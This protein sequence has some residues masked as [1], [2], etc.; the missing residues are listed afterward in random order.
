VDTERDE[1]D[2]SV[3][4]PHPHAGGWAAATT[5]LLGFLALILAQVMDTL[6]A[7]LALLRGLANVGYA[8]SSEIHTNHLALQIVAWATIVVGTLAASTWLVWQYQAHS[9][10]RALP[11]KGMR[12]PPLAA[13]ASWFVPV[14]NLVLPMLAMRELWKATDTDRDLADWKRARTSPWLWLWWLSLLGAAALTFLAFRHALGADLTV[15][16]RTTRDHMAQRAAGVGL[17]SALLGI[18]V[19]QLIRTR[20][21]YR[22][23]RVRFRFWR[24]WAKL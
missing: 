4:V 10:A 18:V 9:N 1:V 22:E 2:E 24:G 14:A 7:D 5:A 17:V 21:A 20:L 15:A 19:L 11:T 3:S 13:V 23:G 12:F 8:S 6:V 16:Q